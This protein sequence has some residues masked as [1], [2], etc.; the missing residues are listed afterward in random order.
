MR[1][2]IGCSGYHYKE[3]RGLFYP[4]GLAM[5]KWLA[6][7]TSQF[8]TLELNNTFYRMPTL[9]VMQRW[10]DQTPADFVFTVKANRLFTHYR[11][12]SGIGAEL[13][14]FYRIVAD[15]LREKARCML[16][17]FPASVAF[18][19][20]LLDRLLQAGGMGWVNVFEFRHISWWQPKVYEALY[21]SGAVF[22]NISIPGLPDVYVPNPQ[23]QY[24]RFHGKEQL[25]ASRY[26][27]EGLAPWLEALQREAPETA[28]IYFNNTASGAAIQ[29]ARH[30]M[31]MLDPQP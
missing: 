24:L 12:M 31:R 29:D 9:P 15:G 20:E 7:Y 8:R 19:D 3:W 18:S 27:T 26:G 11:R 6:Y 4:Q 22:C 5:S 16:F 30:S 1:S 10:Y 25:Y 14:D 17:Q 2:F 21:Q 23:M 28:M 13:L